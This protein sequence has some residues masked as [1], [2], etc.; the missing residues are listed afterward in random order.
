MDCLK[1]MAV[2]HLSCGNILGKTPGALTACSLNIEEQ[3]A[4]MALF[5]KALSL[6][7]RFSINVAMQLCNSH[8]LISIM[9]QVNELPKS[10]FNAFYLLNYSK[11]SNSHN[12]KKNTIE[13]SQL[14]LNSYSTAP[15]C[16][17][18]KWMKMYFVTKG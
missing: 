6:R 11:Q 12:F 1:D 13:I 3:Q 8:F 9:W 16:R 4:V 18:D 17:N 10:H 5:Y 14:L 15:S 7:K 2:F